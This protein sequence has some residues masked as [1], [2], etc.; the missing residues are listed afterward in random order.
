MES[1]CAR[2]SWVTSSGDEDGI[3][4]GVLKEF[5]LEKDSIEDFRERFEFYC[6]ANKIKN[7]GDDLRCKKAL[8]LMLLGH[9]TFSKLKLFSKLKVL[10]SPMPVSDLNIEAIMTLLLAH[11]RSQ[12]IEIT[13]HFK[14]FKRM[15]KPSETVVEFMSELRALAKWCNFG[16][17][18]KTALRD[19]FVCGLKD[20]KCQ[21]EL[22]SIPDLTV[23]VVQRKAQAAKL[24]TVETKWMK[25]PAMEDARQ[26]EDDVNVLHVTCYC[27][28]KA[29]I[30]MPSVMPCCPHP[31]P[32]FQDS[33]LIMHY[34]EV[35]SM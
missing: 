21:Q 14:F 32:S 35:W 15:Q 20:S 10:S 16:E 30:R 33:P 27:C 31:P 24:V 25:E 3:A 34:R 26:Q 18:L 12:T 29:G 22:L 5:D 1:P 2:L 19:Q 9:K 13:E 6:V 4:H 8:F 17:Y 7:D 28:G 23:E 11:C